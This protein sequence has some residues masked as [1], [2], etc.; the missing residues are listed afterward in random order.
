MINRFNRRKFL[1]G[2]SAIALINTV[3]VTALIEKAIAGP[4]A[5]GNMQLG[6]NGV[7]YFNMVMP[8]INQWKAGGDIEIT[9]G[10]LLRTTAIPPG[11]ANSPWGVYID[12]NG[13]LLT[14]GL[15]PS[16]TTQYTRIIYSKNTDGPPVGFSRTGENW[17]LKWDGD[18]NCTI[19]VPLDSVVR[20]GARA[21]GVWGDN[22]NNKLIRFIDF[23]TTN[24]PRNIRYCRADYEAFLDAGE[25]FS[26]D[27]TEQ[28]K[29]GSGI[30]RFM[31]WSNT[32]DNRVNLSYASLPTEAYYSW[33]SRSTSTTGING[34]MPVSLMWKFA[35]KVRSHP[36]ACIPAP[37]GIEKLCSVTAITQATTPVITAPGHTFI[38]GDQVLPYLLGGMTKTATVTMTIASPCVVTWTGNDF[39]IGANIIFSGGT[40]PTGIVAGQS[41]YALGTGDSFQIART[42]GGTAVNTSGSQSGT[43]T[44]EARLNRNKF[45]VQNVVAGV[46]FEIAGAN[47]TTFSAYTSG[48]WFMTPFSLA[49]MTTEM[50]AYATQF[51]DNLIPALT[52]IYEFSNEIWNAG[53]FDSFHL[54]AAQSHDFLDGSNVQIWG[55][56]GNRMG[57]YFAAHFMKTVRDVY[58]VK[59]RTKWKGILPTQTV[60]TGITTAVLAGI[61]RYITDQAPTL[62]LLD[63]FNDLA[64]TGYYGGQLVADAVQSNA[65]NALSMATGT[66]GVF[67]KNFHGL[68]NNQPVKFSTTG[69]LL[70]PLDTATIYYIVNAASNTF[71]VALVQGGTPINLTGTQSGVPT[72]TTAPEEW[73]LGVINTS[74]SRFNSGLEATRYSYFNRIFGE[75]DFDSRWSGYPF[76]ITK[77][78]AFW[79]AQKTIADANGLGLT[80]YE[81]M[82]ATDIAAG[83]YVSSPNF[84]LYLEFYTQY[85]YAAENG[86]NTR[87]IADAFITAGGHHPA[88]Y[89]DVAPVSHFGAFGGLPYIGAQS[90]RWDAD[91][92]FNNKSLGWRP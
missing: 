51:R 44:G 57:G 66:P 35:N 37:F 3:V 7:Q 68:A 72:V 62:T 34:G 70:S 52:A 50:T 55:D 47:T 25:V 28:I 16:N 75:D 69:T 61:S 8:F 53:A 80:Q 71:N 27:Y 24:P 64:V 82:Y 76:S 11:V 40:L 73:S 91:V 58:G 45:T 43:H 18:P 56:D 14:G 31:N 38:N 26:P 86:N 41:Y 79:T 92:D 15:L 33:G 21:T 60:N 13:D 78:I 42:P 67:T 2:I 74:I 39:A 48:G 85:A 89:V 29:R 90:T 9:A 6:L 22:T 83:A 36:W 10:G 23:D 1:F 49:R 46:S 77:V 59:N 88:Q 20:V 4:G 30:V 5:I 81:G 63:L 54:L 12:A 65:S 84:A 19:Q 87:I 17:V 32:N